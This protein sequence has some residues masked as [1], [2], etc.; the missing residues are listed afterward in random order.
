MYLQSSSH[1]SPRQG[2]MSIFPFPWKCDIAST[3]VLETFSAAPTNFSAP[4]GYLWELEYLAGMSVESHWNDIDEDT[5][6]EGLLLLPI[7]LYCWSASA[8]SLSNLLFLSSQEVKTRFAP[9]EISKNGFSPLS[10][11]TTCLFLPSDMVF[12]SDANTCI[13][14][15]QHIDLTADPLTCSPSNFDADQFST[16]G[17]YLNKS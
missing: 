14:D 7:P 1:L 15:T 13:S 12:T 4:S 10:V 3:F 17:V 9:T 8:S 6:D 5:P 16:P 11:S 2:F